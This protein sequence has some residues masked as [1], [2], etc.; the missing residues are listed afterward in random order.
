MHYALKSAVIS[1]NF[2]HYALKSAVTSR[3][4]AHCALNSV[5]FSAHL[6]STFRCCDSQEVI[7]LSGFL[8]LFLDVALGPKA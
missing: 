1:R 8:S 5:V 3:N 4:F 2:V 6:V 7:R